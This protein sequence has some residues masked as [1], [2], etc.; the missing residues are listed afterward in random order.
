MKKTENNE[1]LYFLDW[2]KEDGINVNEW[3]ENMRPENQKLGDILYQTADEFIERTEVRLYVL[4]AFLWL[5][6]IVNRRHILI[7][8]AL[9]D[10]LH[11][12]WKKLVN[13]NRGELTIIFSKEKIIDFKIVEDEKLIKF[14]GD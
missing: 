4:N 9:L 10:N 6:T 1:I 13:D 8:G 5:A 7:S 12:R 2:L 3:L 11:D 14:E